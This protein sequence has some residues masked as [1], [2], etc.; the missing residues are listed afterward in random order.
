M[1]FKKRCF[2]CV[3]MTW[4]AMS[5][6][7][8]RGVGGGAGAGPGLRAL[9]S[10]SGPVHA[11]VLSRDFVLVMTAGNA[12]NILGAGLDFLQ[13]SGALAADR[14]ITRAVGGRGLHS[15]T[16]QLNLSRF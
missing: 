14:D 12:A 7:P 1:C 16:S 15:S 13:Y 2:N 6:R 3:S 11:P 4:R 8:Y 9:I 5:T 10:G